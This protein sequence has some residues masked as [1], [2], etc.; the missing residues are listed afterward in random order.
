MLTLEQRKK[1]AELLKKRKEALIRQRELRRQKTIEPIQPPP[2]EPIKA[3]EVVRK[4]VPP[5]KVSQKKV[6]LAQRKGSRKTALPIKCPNCGYKPDEETVKQFNSTVYIIGGGPSLEHFNW[7]LLDESKFIIAINRAYETI[8]NAQIVYF[9]DDDWYNTH[10][11]RRLLQH[12]GVKIKGS[13]SP[14]RM[15]AD[16]KIYQMHLTGP[17]GLDM[18]PGCLKHGRNSPYAAT[19]MV[20]QWGFKKV[21]YLGIDMGFGRPDPTS[22]HKRKSHWHSGHR[23]TDSLSTYQSFIKGYQALPKLI[24]P[25]GVTIININDVQKMPFFKQETYKEHFGPNWTTQK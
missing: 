12:K 3:P 14:S 19:N 6:P 10:K 17:S 2:K 13:L 8:P 16:N 5:P 15:S 7:K 1:R 4:E 23:R 9:T 11:S 22:K 24:E 25:Y 20:I 18:T 21:Y